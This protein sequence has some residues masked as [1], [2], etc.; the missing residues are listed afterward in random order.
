MSL[1]CAHV[2][3]H[4]ILPATKPAAQLSVNLE[5]GNLGRAHRVNGEYCN[6]KGREREREGGG[7]NGEL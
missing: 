6:G 3:M 4:P 5:K 7:G 1:F 2:D